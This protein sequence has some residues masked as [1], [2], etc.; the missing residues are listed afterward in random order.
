MDFLYTELLAR[1]NLIMLK[2]TMDPLMASL[3][4]LESNQTVRIG[5][6]GI[7]R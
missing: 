1:G 6:S 3:A 5:K 4:I 2:G 7:K